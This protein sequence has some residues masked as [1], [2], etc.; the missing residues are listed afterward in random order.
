MARHIRNTLDKLTPITSSQSA[1]SWSRGRLTPNDAGVVDEDVEPSE[2]LESRRRRTS[3]RAACRAGP[4]SGDACA[5]RRI[6]AIAAAV[7]PGLACSHAAQH[8]RPPTQA[9]SPSL[10]PARARRRSPAPPCR[11]VETDPGDIGSRLSAHRT[12]AGTPRGSARRCRSAPPLPRASSRHAAM[13]D[14]KCSRSPALAMRRWPSMM[15]STRPRSTMRDL[16]VRMR[17]HGRHDARLEAQT[18]DHQLLAPD[19]LALDAVGDALDGNR[20]TSRDV[21]TR[22]SDSGSFIVS[23]TGLCRG[24]TPSRQNPGGR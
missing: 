9:R 16:L 2:C 20:S 7:R 14:G 23:P 5:A 18:A 11:R 24:Q 6:D 17:V 13:C 10:R 3:A 19:H 15:N 1:S 22:A 4:R 8:P 12:A 21:E